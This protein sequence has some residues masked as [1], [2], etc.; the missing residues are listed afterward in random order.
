MEKAGTNMQT[1]KLGPRD[2]LMRVMEVGEIEKDQK[3]HRKLLLE[4]N[5]MMFVL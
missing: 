1:A 2:P 3:L 4:M 5:E